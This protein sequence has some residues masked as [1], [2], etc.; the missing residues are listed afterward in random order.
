M[1]RVRR[2]RAGRRKAERRVNLRRVIQNCNIKLPQRFNNL[3][4]VE[5]IYD[6]EYEKLF[7]GSFWSPTPPTPW[8]LSPIEYPEPRYPWLPPSH[9]ADYDPRKIIYVIRREQ[10]LAEFY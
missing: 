5:S 10:I 8:R 1:H 3:L 6:E 4:G 7:T 9:I 2:H